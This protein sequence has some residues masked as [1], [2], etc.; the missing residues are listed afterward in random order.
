MTD[1]G[2]LAEKIPLSV[3]DRTWAEE[4]AR[5]SLTDATP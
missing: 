1:V 2:A 3:D 4:L 5:P